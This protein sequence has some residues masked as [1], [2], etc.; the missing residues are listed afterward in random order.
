MKATQSNLAIESKVSRK[1]IVE[2]E[3]GNSTIQRK[4]LRKI[5]IGLDVIMLEFDER[6]VKLANNEYEVEK[7]WR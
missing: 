5:L 4:T 2:A 1:T 6:K 7:K 3:S